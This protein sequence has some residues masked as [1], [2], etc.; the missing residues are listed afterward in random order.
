MSP[1]RATSCPA[2]LRRIDERETF[3][4]LQ[5]LDFGPQLLDRARRRGLIE[6]LLLGRLHFG[7]RCVVQVFDIF[8][9]EQWNPRVEHAATWPPRCRN[10]QLAQAASQAAR[11]DG[12]ATGKSPP[13]KTRGGAEEW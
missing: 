5:R 7:V 12:E 1:A 13:E 9:V 4:M 6:N 10:F 2:P 3:E 8:L 11:A